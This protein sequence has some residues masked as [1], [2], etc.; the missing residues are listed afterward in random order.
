MSEI[1]SLRVRPE[2]SALMR[3]AASEAG[4]SVSRLIRD[5]VIAQICLEELRP[6]RG[7]AGAETRAP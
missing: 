4:V 2:L 3:S 1:V 5:S 6:E 7:A